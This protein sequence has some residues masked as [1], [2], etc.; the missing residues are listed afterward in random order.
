MPLISSATRF[1]ANGHA[2]IV[3]RLLLERRHPG[4]AGDVDDDAAHFAARGERDELAAKRRRRRARDRGVERDLGRV[5]EDHRL[6][7]GRRHRRSRRERGVGDA[8]AGRCALRHAQRERT[9]RIEGAAAAGDPDVE[10]S[11]AVP[12]VDD[13]RLVARAR[14]RG[15]GDDASRLRGRE[16]LRDLGR[17]EDGRREHGRA[18][19]STG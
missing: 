15:D 1:F 5:G 11:G 8:H 3:R 7:A 13:G 9:A 10:V 6:Q 16:R 18:E 12:R 19:D 4:I 14:C 2:G 17:A